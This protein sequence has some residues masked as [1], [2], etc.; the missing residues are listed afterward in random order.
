[1]QLAGQGVAVDDAEPGQVG[2]QMRAAALELPAALQHMN[3]ITERID[4]DVGLGRAPVFGPRLDAR[5]NQPGREVLAVFRIGVPVRAGR[6]S[7]RR[8]VAE[9]T[10]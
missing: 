4:R 10:R 5:V 1:V 3:Q 2:L 8:S 9:V 6:R 7:P